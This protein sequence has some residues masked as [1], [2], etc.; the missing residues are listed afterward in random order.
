MSALNMEMAEWT[1]LRKDP[2][3]QKRIS[4]GEKSI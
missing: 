3:S 1:L 2:T 4:Q